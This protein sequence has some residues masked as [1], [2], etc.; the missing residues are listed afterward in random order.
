MPITHATLHLF[1]PRFELSIAN[2]GRSFCETKHE[3]IQV[4]CE[5]RTVWV[6]HSVEMTLGFVRK[7]CSRCL[8]VDEINRCEE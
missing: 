2:E 3:R 1:I 8:D 7:Y 6:E 4:I 5:R